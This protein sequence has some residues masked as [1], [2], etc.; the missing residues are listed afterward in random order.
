MYDVLAAFLAANYPR[1][2]TMVVQELPLIVTQ[3]GFT[4]VDSVLGK[5][6]NASVAFLTSDPYV[7]TELIGITV[8]DA[9][10]YS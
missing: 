5:Q 2:Y 7:S 8:L 6:I 10:I 9:I 1:A 4:K 3:D